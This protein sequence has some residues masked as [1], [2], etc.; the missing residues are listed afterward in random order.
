MKLLSEN[1]NKNYVKY[2]LAFQYINIVKQK[3][4]L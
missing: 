4:S 2:F 1:I 3:L